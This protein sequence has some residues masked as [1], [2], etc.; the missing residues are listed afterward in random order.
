MGGLISWIVWGLFVGAFARL[1]VP[2]R[3]AIGCVWT[4]L[5]GVAGSIGGGLIATKLLKI[6]SVGS[7]GFGSFAFAVVVS[8]LALVI[9]ERISA[10]RAERRPPDPL[11][12]YGRGRR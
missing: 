7:F 11:D 9:F 3:Q 4:I 1:L 2:G 6:N 5:L 12:P 10:Y 8:A